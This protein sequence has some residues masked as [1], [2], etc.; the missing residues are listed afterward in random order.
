VSLD[1][2]T[3][4]APPTL[5]RNITPALASCLATRSAAESTFLAII[6]E[7]DPIPRSDLGYWM[8]L[9]E[10]LRQIRQ[11]Q[12]ESPR[13]PPPTARTMGKLVMFRDVRPDAER[14]DI[15][16]YVVEEEALAP[17]AFVN[18]CVHYMHEHM[19]LVDLAFC[20]RLHSGSMTESSGP[21]RSALTRSAQSGQSRR[22]SGWQLSG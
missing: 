19:N 17:A 3:F 16:M 10:A 6:T 12:Q 2:I 11:P 21:S 4:G 1:C 9:A 5:S 20:L 7:G 22:S 13:V 14:R 18:M 15:R 8:F